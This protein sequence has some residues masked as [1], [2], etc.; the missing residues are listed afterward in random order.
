[1]RSRGAKKRAMMPTHKVYTSDAN[2]GRPKYSLSFTGKT[3]SKLAATPMACCP[4]L[5]SDA[6]ATQS[7]PIIATTEPPLYSMIL[8]HISSPSV[9]QSKPRDEP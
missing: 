2:P 1:M 7:F 6:M 5:K 8:W 9:Y 3:L 4:N